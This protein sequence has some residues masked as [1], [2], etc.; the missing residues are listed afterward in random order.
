M[1]EATTVAETGGSDNQPAARDG[2]TRPVALTARWIA[3]ARANESTR[4]N[5]LFD[6]PYAEAL[7]TSPRLGAAAGGAL[8]A[9]ASAVDEAIVQASRAFGAPFLAIRTRFFDELLLH[10]VRSEEHTSELQSPM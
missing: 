8:R 6:D 1:P 2:E 5:R 3:A 4:P 10:A 7:A 9:G